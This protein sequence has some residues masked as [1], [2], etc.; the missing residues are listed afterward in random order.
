MTTLLKNLFLNC[1]L[2]ETEQVVFTKLLERGKS[3]A[4]VLASLTGI[5][6]PTVYAA[7]ENLVRMSL[8]S[9]N[10][11]GNV[12]YFSPVSLEVIPKI[13]QYQAKKKFESIKDSTKLMEEQLKNFSV[14]SLN[15]RIFETIALES[16]EAVYTQLENTLLGGDFCAFFNPQKV[17]FG[18]YKDLVARFLKETAKTKPH[19][20]E[21]AVS[22]PLTQWYKKHMNNKNHILKE[23]PPDT[24]VVSDVLLIKGSVILIDYDPKKEAAVK[25]T[26]GNH[27]RS[28]M[29]LFET[30]WKTI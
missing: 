29:A 19:I 22:G 11:S 16:I 10:R 6:R 8:V 12:T 18:D 30:L 9:K 25:I 2:N 26:H 28:M 14:N 1:G 24:D 7:L 3:I 13:F 20:R 21:I 4:S 15:E 17:I 5:K 23:L 27:F